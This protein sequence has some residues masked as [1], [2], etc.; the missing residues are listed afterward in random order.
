MYVRWLCRYCLEDSLDEEKVKGKIVLCLGGKESGLRQSEEVKNN[1]G[2]GIIIGNDPKNGNDM[3][4]E[5][6]QIPS[7]K[8]AF[9]DTKKLIHYIKATNDPKA[10]ILLAHTSLN[11]KPAPTISTF[12]GRGPNPFDPNFIKVTSL[13]IYIYMCII[14]IIFITR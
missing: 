8:V 4:L 6:Y 9:E 3:S 1:Y 12:S 2:V 11:S 13:S 14:L 7:S 10:R 5:P